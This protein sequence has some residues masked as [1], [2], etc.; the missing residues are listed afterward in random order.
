MWCHLEPEPTLSSLRFLQVKDC[1]LQTKMVPRSSH[2][3]CFRLWRKWLPW[4]SAL[5]QRENPGHMVLCC[6]L[7]VPLH[8]LWHFE[9]TQM[10][11]SECTG[12][13]L[14]PEPEHT[15]TAKVLGKRA[16]SQGL[17]PGFKYPQ[18]SC[19]TQ[20]RP[21]TSL[22]VIFGCDLCEI[23]RVVV[24]IVSNDGLRHRGASLNSGVPEWGWSTPRGFPPSTPSQPYRHPLWLCWP[25]ACSHSGGP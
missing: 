21:L 14:E 17:R 9:T 8:S 12:T 20:D 5:S 2:G 18:G 19:V 16:R 25:S 3:A 4:L 15:L 22:R 10:W 11:L 24:T 23:T 7:A 13:S 6:R 1:S